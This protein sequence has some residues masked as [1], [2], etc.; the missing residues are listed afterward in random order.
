LGIAI[1]IAY[2]ES[3]QAEGQLQEKEL[4]NKLSGISAKRPIS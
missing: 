3:K 2:T 1:E 4:I